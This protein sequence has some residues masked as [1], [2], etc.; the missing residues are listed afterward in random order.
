MSFVKNLEN[1]T[2]SNSFV[3]SKKSQ[4][5][6]SKHMYLP[7]RITKIFKS[8]N[9]FKCRTSFDNKSSS[10]SKSKK[11]NGVKQKTK[12]S[13]G[14]VT[15]QV[16]GCGADGAPA[17]VYLFTD[18][19]RYLFNCGEGTQ[20][21]AHE[22]KTKLSRLQH[23]FFTDKCWSKLGGLPGLALTAQDAGVSQLTLHG[24]TELNTLFQAMNR[25]VVL[26][27]IQ[28]ETRSSLV[29]DVFEDEVMNVYAVPIFRSENNL[30]EKN[31]KA[32]TISYVC[33][34][35]PRPGALDLKKCVEKGVPPGP[36]L[37][38][39]KNGEDVV[40]DDGTIVKSSDVSEPSS[41]D[42]I[43]IFVDIPNEDCL[44]SLNHQF[45]NYKSAS[46]VV[47]FAPERIVSTSSYE[48]FLNSFEPETTHIFL[49]SSNKFSG[50]FAAHRFQI[51]LNQLHKRIFPLLGE[52]PNADDVT[53]EFKRSKLNNQC[54]NGNIISSEQLDSR[55]ISD[56]A[57]LTCFR[58]RPNKGL[59]R[60]M[61]LKY[62]PEEYLKE[63]HALEGFTDALLTLRST[64]ENEN[65]E[66][67]PEEKVF[68]KITFLGTGS[69]IPNKTRNVS[70]ILLQPKDN[71][72]VLLDCGEGTLGQII[73]FF[74]PLRWREVVKNIK[75]IYISHLHA[76][77]HIG[78]IG[79]LKERSKLLGTEQTPLY[80]FAPLQIKSWLSYYNDIIE[81][82][83]NSY[84]LIPN[85]EMVDVPYM[86]P[87]LKNMGINSMSTCLVR[88]CQHSFGVS[89]LLDS[90][91]EPIKITY[92]GD[93]MPCEDLIELGYDSTILIHEA[94][95][96]DELLEEAKIKMH[97]T[98]SQA[99]SVA[100]KMNAK[101]TILTHFS[102]RYAKLPRIP[103]GLL[104]NV[105]IAFD[106][107]QVS[108]GDL[109]NFSLMYPVM[110]LMF[111]EHYEEM[112][113]KTQMR[114]IKSERKRKSNT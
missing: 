13:P 92:S 98:I 103:E 75:S 86:S 58:L 17:S 49:N 100:Q 53:E 43:I 9:F 24:P 25:F 54:S 32:S 22:H 19:S 94:T 51:Q 106:F 18:Q 27:K 112:E 7:L 23:I 69:C 10:F 56:A 109:K 105:A 113:R 33:K 41:G 39:L 52:V 28:I 79:M 68:P 107:M 47:H 48:K 8:S 84:K 1:L 62:T 83:A 59:D 111:S 37:G 21:L 76:D 34:L 99:L 67:A 110:K 16:L 70:A 88:H 77:H 78:L 66:K 81:P 12:Y 36:L 82:I 38:L 40:L 74:G 104:S 61:E 108:M 89:L 11:M 15:L 29:S 30:N 35:K 2:F 87:V 85:A 4:K 102:Q 6:K 55:L 64:L 73:R 96:E 45:E 46:V 60:S 95:M 71:S 20:R 91:E 3:Y 97:C 114:L 65:I 57:S 101:H 50:H 31:E 80:L 5:L 14:T 44:N 26:K 72:Y 90:V 63:T 42:Q 93:T